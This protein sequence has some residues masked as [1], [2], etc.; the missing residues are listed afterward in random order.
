MTPIKVFDSS[1]ASITFDTER[2]IIMVIWNG[3]HT[4][5]EYKAA[6]GEAL[7]FQRISGFP[8]YTYLSD[9]R[10]QGIVNPESRKWFER[11]AIPKAV[12]KGLRRAAVV[13]DGSVFKSHYLSLVL[14]AANVYQ[15]P[16]K[17]FSSMDEANAW[18][19]SFHD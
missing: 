4:V 5:S 15:L 16:L 6:I 17:F 11:V 19:D 7:N 14:M 13:Y 3:N 12:E 10:N 8:V 18:I 9:I 1:Y 2:K